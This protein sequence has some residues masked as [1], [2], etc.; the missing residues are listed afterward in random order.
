MQPEG[1]GI[2][3]Q[4]TQPEKQPEKDLNSALSPFRLTIQIASRL[5]W[6][7]SWAGSFPRCLSSTPAKQVGHTT[8][9]PGMLEGQG[10]LA[11]GPLKKHQ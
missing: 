3:P 6:L 4:A 1:Q 2:L 7:E 9:L 10:R 8:E 5:W 11:P